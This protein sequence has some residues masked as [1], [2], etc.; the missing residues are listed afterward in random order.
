MADWAPKRF[1]K[2][3]EAVETAEGWTVRLDGRAVKTPAKAALLLPSRAFAEAVAGEWDAQVETV[4]PATMPLTRLANSAIDNVAHQHAAVAAMLSEYGGTDLLCYRAEAPADLADAQGAAWDPLLI[5][6]A[7]Q[8][9]APLDTGAGVMHLPQPPA[10]LAALAAEVHALDAFELS[11]FHDLVTI[12]GSLVIALAVIHGA[13]TPHDAWTAS[14]IDEDWQARQW[15]E[16]EEAAAIA[17]LKREAFL[18]AHRAF[19]LIR[20]I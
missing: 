5:W 1:W 2:A 20:A 10:S 7:G 17:A 18:T 12:S 13:I 14:R 4:D 8:F 6:S 19:T 3:A 11:A 16:D 9:G 15:G